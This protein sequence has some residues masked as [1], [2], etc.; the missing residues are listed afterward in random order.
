MH[1]Y[2]LMAVIQGLRRDKELFEKSLEIE[3]G[4]KIE[5]F[6]RE[7]YQKYGHHIIPDEDEVKLPGVTSL[8]RGIEIKS[9]KNED[10][11]RLDVSRAD[12]EG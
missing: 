3:G 8:L 12:E 7:Y 6:C 9:E 5:Y 1:I 11:N 10:S 2:G 4:D